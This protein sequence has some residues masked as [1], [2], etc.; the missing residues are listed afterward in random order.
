M[1][2]VPFLSEF[3]SLNLIVKIPLLILMGM[4]AIF[5]FML[6]IRLHSLSQIVFFPSRVWTFGIRMFGYI[7]FF[8]VISLFVA[9]LVIV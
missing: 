9:T 6:L 5:I 4:Y 2:T 8:L 3:I 1:I 7:Y